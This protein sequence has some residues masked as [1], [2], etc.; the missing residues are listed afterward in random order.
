MLE[1]GFLSET[2]K[3]PATPERFSKITLI[4]FPGI[5]NGV[6]D[7]A[8]TPFLNSKYFNKEAA[9]KPFEALAAKGIQTETVH[10]A[11]NKVKASLPQIPGLAIATN[12]HA[13]YNDPEY[14]QRVMEMVSQTIDPYLAQEDP[15]LICFQTHSFGAVVLT[16][17]LK[18]AEQEGKLEAFKAK[19]GAFDVMMLSPALD[20]MGAGLISSKNKIIQ[21][22]GMK[23]DREAIEG[24]YRSRARRVLGL[25]IKGDPLTGRWMPQGENI[26]NLTLEPEWGRWNTFVHAITTGNAHHWGIFTDPNAQW[27]MTEWLKGTN[28]S[29]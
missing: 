5:G 24:I 14:K 29:I 22:L 10:V 11:W 19:G 23:V 18:K 25:S 7:E 13:Y 6:L 4:Q 28:L 26:T 20:E 1:D 17:Y 12:C 15:G 21:T 16:D 3:K 2:R 27:V 8:K 9:G